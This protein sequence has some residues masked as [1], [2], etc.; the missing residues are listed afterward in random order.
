MK[1][2]KASTKGLEFNEDFVTAHDFLENTQ[3]NIFVTGKAGTGKSTLLKYF[4]E[5]TYK[6][7]AVLAPTGVAAINI[8][9]QTIHSFFRFKPDITPEG[10]REIRIPKYQRK[11]FENLDVIIID[12]ISMVRA[13]LLDC[14]ELFLQLHGRYKDLPFGGV[15]MVFFGDLY[16]LPPVVTRDQR[17]IFTSVYKSPFFF[18]AKSFP[19][20][21]LK[22]IELSKVY[23][24]K[25]KDFVQLLNAIRNKTADFHD[26]KKLNQRFRPSINLKDD[27]FYIF[28]TTTNAVADQ[29]N[30]EQLKK[31]KTKSHR[32]EGELTGDFDYK[33]LPTNLILDLKEG[34]QVMLL[35]NDQNGRWVN[36]S[37]GKIVTIHETEP[38]ITVELADGDTVEVEAHAWEM[39]RYFY[40]EEQGR[41]DSESV[42]AFMQ[43]PLRLAWAV[44]IHKSQGKTFSK[45][46]VDMGAGAFSHGQTYVALSRCTSFEGLLL[47]K[48]ISKDHLRLDNRVIDFMASLVGK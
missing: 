2:N 36:G 44:T 13:D 28:L 17:S 33:S 26:I 23:R 10:V 32:F 42:G 31:L 1:S 43:F 46:I 21:D 27:E 3:K 34:A 9:G 20:L 6:N 45:V 24:Q 30:Q 22:V 25:E 29:I 18:D 7:V 19:F 5:K 35:N 37:L 15:Q 39:Y 11:I 48:P 16:Q 4:R 38:M 40:D 47:R 41:L 12:E 14:I 8:Q